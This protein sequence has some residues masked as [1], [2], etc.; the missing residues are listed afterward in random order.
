M[1]LRLYV[2]KLSQMLVLHVSEATECAEKVPGLHV[3][4]ATDYQLR[5]PGFIRTPGR[6]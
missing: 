4:E 6:S 5:V 1:Q 2:H 3:D